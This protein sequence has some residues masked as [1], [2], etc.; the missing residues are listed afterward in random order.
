MKKFE[1][2]ILQ[3]C[4]EIVSKNDLEKFRKADLE[5]ENYQKTLGFAKLRST[6]DDVR[7]CL[8]AFQRLFRIMPD[9]DIAVEFIRISKNE[10]FDFRRNVMSQL[11][12]K[13]D[14]QV[15]NLLPNKIKKSILKNHRVLYRNE[16]R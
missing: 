5:D 12:D 11:P 15:F 13:V 14:I 7:E 3:K 16:R 4:E 2:K 8:K 9:I 6:K 10:A 1:D